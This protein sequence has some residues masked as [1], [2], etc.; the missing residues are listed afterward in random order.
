MTA[1]SKALDYPREH[2]DWIKTIL[3]GG[4]LSVFAFL[5]IPIF[6]VYGYILRVLRRRLDNDPHPPVFD[7]WGELLV[8]GLQV[9][10]IGIIYMFIPVLV[11]AITAG[12]SILAIATGTRGGSAAG[13]AGLIVGFLLTLVL[14]LVFGYVA[15]AAIV[16]FA[17]E[18]RLGAA[19]DFATLRTIVF[20]GD[21]AVAWL[22]SVAV[23]I[24]AG[25]VAGLLNIV[26]FLGAII[27]AFIGFYAQIMAGYLWA[28]GYS[29]AREGSERDDWS[30]GEESTV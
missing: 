16:N 9:F 12:G 13:M 19:F 7:E 4:V 20:D 24:G 22:L 1:I 6:L 10:V 14:S 3:I 23:L 30:R 27:G 17:R 18:D 15:V 8:N 28:G 5:L 29:A 11:G 26:P 21:Y 2:D 25:I